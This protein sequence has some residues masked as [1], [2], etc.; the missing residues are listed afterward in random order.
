MFR[1]ASP[2]E[3][4]LFYHEEWGADRLP[5]YIVKSLKNR[6]F[7]FDYD[8][9]GPKDRYRSF[10]SLTQLEGQIVASKPYAAYTSVSLYEEPQKRRG[11]LSAELVFDIDAKDLPARSC[12]CS[13]GEVCER[14]LQDAKEY[15]LRFTEDLKDI[16]ALRDINFVY[17]GRGYHLRVQDRE[18]VGLSSQERAELLDYISGNVV[19]ED[20]RGRGYPSIFRARAT[21]VL[22]FLGLDQLREMGLTKP[23]AEKLQE[24]LP[25][26]LPELKRGDFSRVR[27]LLKEK[28]NYTAF[29]EGLSKVNASM[30]DAR[31]TVDIKRILRLPTSLHSKVSMVCTPVRDLE[32]FDPLKHAVP[33]FARERD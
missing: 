9:E 12:S 29:L 11:W 22:P 3:R 8:G 30:V 10:V 2:E 18:V 28:K 13:E 7:A 15:V 21:G 20:L 25:S 1:E 19:P 23:K 6:E 4:K 26:L 16:F 5:D 14:C 24:E 33:R 27:R 32:S 31:V 17:S